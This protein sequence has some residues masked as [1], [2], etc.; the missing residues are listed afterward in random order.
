MPLIVVGVNHKAAPVE[1]RERLAF[2]A[3]SLGAAL[4]CAR[5]VASETVILSTC[6]RTEVYALMGHLRS[7]ERDLRRFIRSFH[8]LPPEFDSYL[9]VHAQRDAVRH[10][11][12]VAS[13]LDSMIVGEAQVLGQV[14][15][16][17]DLARAGGATG[18]IFSRLFRQAIQVGKL[19]RS[20]TEIGKHA[21]SVSYAA[22]ELACHVFGDLRTRRVLIAGAGDMAELT[23]RHLADRGVASVTVLNRTYEHARELAARY[24]GKAL[25]LEA[26]PQAL[27]TAD[28]A[29]GSTG[30]SSFLIGPEHVRTAMHAR[31]SD[32]ML[33]I[34][35]AVPRDIDPE[36]GRI[37]NA[38]LY[39]VD[40]LEALC[41]HNLRERQREALK[42]EDLVEV[43]ADRFLEWWAGLEVVPTIT[44][45]RARAEQIRE[46]EVSKALARMGR[47]SEREHNIVN[48]MS[49]ALVNKLLH[50]PITRMKGDN[51]AFDY[52]RVVRH[53]FDLETARAEDTGDIPLEQL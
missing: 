43:E 10:L 18:P 33:L 12:R 28:I 2:T 22:A 46:G 41:A 49:Q 38:Y 29:I 17:F 31:G 4:Q 8:R 45:L 34:D 7:G 40:D 15:D 3:D 48:A 53:L 1:V 52:A 27:A 36:V 39:N 24:G 42:I 25:P 51:G 14:R 30:A 32:P 11:F 16:A 26:L 13:S 35:V 23:L 50:V 6:N 20:S 47:L 37:A 9:Y 44:A 21:V 19:A 5:E